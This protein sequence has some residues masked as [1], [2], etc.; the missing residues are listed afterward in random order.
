M[1]QE[2]KGVQAE[3]GWQAVPEMVGPSFHPIAL[4]SGAQS[5]HPPFYN[6]DHFADFTYSCP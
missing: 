4:S 2:D 5:P 3:L 1:L 6:I